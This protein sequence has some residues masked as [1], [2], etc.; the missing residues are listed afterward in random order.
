MSLNA[1]LFILAAAV[2]SAALAQQAPAAGPGRGAGRGQAAPVTWITSSPPAQMVP[3]PGQ[4]PTVLLWPNG[5]PARRGRRLARSTASM[6][7]R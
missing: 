4:H 3:N 1:R 7:T 2:A 5:A 6:A